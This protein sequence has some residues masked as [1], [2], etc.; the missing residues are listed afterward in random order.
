MNRLFRG[1]RPGFSSRHSRLLLWAWAMLTYEEYTYE[2]PFGHT[3]QRLSTVDNTFIEGIGNMKNSV[4]L[5]FHEVLSLIFKDHV[6]LRKGLSD[7]DS[8][9]KH[10]SLVKRQ[11]I[12][13]S[14][15]NGK[16]GVSIDVLSG[17]ILKFLPFRDLVRISEVSR[18]FYIASTCEYVWIRFSRKTFFK[19][20]RLSHIISLFAYRKIACAFCFNTAR[21]W[22]RLG[23]ADEKKMFP[24][25]DCKEHQII[26]TI[27]EKEENST[28]YAH[29]MG[30]RQTVCLGE[31]SLSVPLEIHRLNFIGYFT[32]FSTEDPGWK[33]CHLP[34]FATEKVSVHVTEIT[35]RNHQPKSISQLHIHIP[36]KY[37]PTRRVITIPKLPK[38]FSK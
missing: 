6:K 29:F 18:E 17:K 13:L 37:H 10:G 31:I 9:E 20:S 7:Y 1:K 12:V 21:R 16:F 2:H 25:L 34:Y 3:K 38:F 27:L 33:S 15:E 22:G 23:A 35:A 28:S 19:H 30:R 11:D 8:P 26:D 24:F 14:K 5:D 4:P 36:G 32:F